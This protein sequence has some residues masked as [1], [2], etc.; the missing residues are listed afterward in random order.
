MPSSRPDAERAI[1]DF[2]KAL[3][4]DPTSDILRDT[5][6]R[7]VDAFV[8]ELLAGYGVD[9]PELLATGSEPAQGANAGIVVVR[10][11]NVSTVCPHHLMP[12]I[13]SATVAYEPGKRI[14]GIGTLAKLVQTYAR[15]L[16]LQE[17]IGTN[18]VETLIAH[19]AR[20]AYCRLELRH[21]CLSARGAEQ[22]HASVAS[23]AT[24]GNFASEPG[25]SAL[26]L[27]LGP[28]P[29]Q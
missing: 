8:D 4:H 24:G 13:G 5:P 26:A 10:H 29:T 3:G 22:H 6:R 27:A 23:T 21:S 11:V 14:L 25:L 7:V 18:V 17:Q 12:A 9:I 15:R 20:G 1:R 28:E 2:L 19:G 16:S